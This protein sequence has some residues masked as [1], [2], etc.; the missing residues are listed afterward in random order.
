MPARPG[1]RS[2]ASSERSGPRSGCLTN[3]VPLLASALRLEEFFQAY[4]NLVV[5]AVPLHADHVLQFA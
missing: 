2:R 5:S 4:E 3:A 1:A